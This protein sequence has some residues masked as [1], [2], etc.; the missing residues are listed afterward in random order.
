MN[1]CGMLDDLRMSAT[2]ARG[3]S[4]DRGEQG[5]VFEGGEPNCGHFWAR[6]IG[7]REDCS[8]EFAHMSIG[9]EMRYFWRPL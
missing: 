9:G 4:G 1:V 8:W 5:T 6:L 3:K 2:F 7:S